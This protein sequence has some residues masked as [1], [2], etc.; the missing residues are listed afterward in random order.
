[1]DR[2]S[3]PDTLKPARGVM[4]EDVEGY[5][6]EFIRLMEMSDLLKNNPGS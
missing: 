2:S 5:R 3:I 1:M 4:S 6:A